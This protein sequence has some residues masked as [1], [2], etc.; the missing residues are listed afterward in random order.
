MAAVTLPYFKHFIS[1]D[2]QETEFLSI[3]ATG[4]FHRL[5]VKFFQFGALPTSEAEIQVLAKWPAKD[6]NWKA[7]FDEL[8]KYVFTK[9]WRNPKWEA[10]LGKS[11]ATSENNAK[12][13][14]TRW[15]PAKAPQ[16]APPPDSYNGPDSYDGTDDEPDAML[17]Q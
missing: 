17:Y 10:V 9:D 7:V 5:Q 14:K 15:E 2:V 8:Q 16:P 1:D 13:A 6:R 11:R 12:S 4:V 3:A